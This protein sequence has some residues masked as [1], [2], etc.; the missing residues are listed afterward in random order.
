MATGLFTDDTG[1]SLDLAPLPSAPLTSL[2]PT[3]RSL[4]PL[5]KRLLL[6]ITRGKFVSF[7]LI[8]AATAHVS[9][10]RAADRSPLFSLAISA[11][12]V[13]GPALDVLPRALSARER[14]T[15]FHSWLSAFNLFMRAATHFRPH[16]SES[17]IRYQ[18]IIA[19][20]AHAYVPGAWLA[21]DIA[22]RHHVANNPHIPWD[23]VDEEIFT[24][25][26]RCATS[27]SRCF[28]CQSP[29]HLAAQCSRSHAPSRRGATSYSTMAFSGS[30]PPVASSAVP[31]SSAP[32]RPRVGPTLVCHSWNGVRGCARF[33]CRFLHQ[34]AVCGGPHRRG[35]CN[36]S[37]SS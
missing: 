22:F 26:L 17:L 29:A 8:F 33:M 31:P 19:G 4:P 37:S 16:L 2:A 7:D 9:S 28:I 30:R 34:C 21:Y 12:G 10:V 18:G 20:F 25:H 36:S 5:P 15:N 32:L 24:A 3:P 27:L 13:G 1:M 11:D 35:D 23:R 6:L 14:V